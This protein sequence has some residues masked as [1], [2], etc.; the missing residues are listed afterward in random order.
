MTAKMMAMAQGMMGQMAQGIP[1]PPS[2]PRGPVN[3]MAME[4]PADQG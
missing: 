1:R 3:G 2:T 4:H